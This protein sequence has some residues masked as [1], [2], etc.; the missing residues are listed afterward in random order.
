MAAVEV[1]PAFKL[2]FAS[3]VKKRALAQLNLKVVGLKPFDV[4]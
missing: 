1:A 3:R 4:S 2:G